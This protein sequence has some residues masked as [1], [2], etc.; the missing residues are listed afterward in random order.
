M[1]KWILVSKSAT[2]NPWNPRSVGVRSGKTCTPPQPP[3]ASVKSW[4]SATKIWAASIFGALTNKFLTRVG[5]KMLYM[6]WRTWR[7]SIAFHSHLNLDWSPCSWPTKRSNGKIQNIQDPRD[8]PTDTWIDLN[9]RPENK[10]QIE[11]K[12]QRHEPSTKSKPRK[13]WDVQDWRSLCLKFQHLYRPFQ[14]HGTPPKALL[15]HSRQ[16]LA[17]LQPGPS[18]STNG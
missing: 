4:H 8:I 16:L 10:S 11:N 5:L 2:S 1:F 15:Q 9:P 13:P 17:P 18:S 12:S 3:D 14:C 7:H 6:K